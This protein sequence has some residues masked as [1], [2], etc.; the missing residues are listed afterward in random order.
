MR[1]EGLLADRLTNESFFCSLTFFSFFW[2]TFSVAPYLQYAPA[3]PVCSILQPCVS[4]RQKSECRC[5]LDPR[6]TSTCTKDACSQLDAERWKK[7]S[8]IHET[9][10]YLPERRA[11]RPAQRQADYW[12]FFRLERDGTFLPLIFF[13]HTST[14]ALYLLSLTCVKQSRIVGTTIFLRRSYTTSMALESFRLAELKY[15]I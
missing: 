5:L 3:I 15:A 14:A 2:R 13:F 7:R 1:A 10:D 9:P 11:E 8:T 4:A 6:N 12:I